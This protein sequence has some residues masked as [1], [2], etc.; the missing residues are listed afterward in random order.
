MVVLI[1]HID[2]FCI[3]EGASRKGSSGI[4]D[5][6]FGCREMEVDR[7]GS[8]VESVSCLTCKV[9]VEVSSAVAKCWQPVQ[10]DL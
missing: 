6:F 9:L 3:F 7:H 2:L 5:T 1:L 8:E 4:S 10:S